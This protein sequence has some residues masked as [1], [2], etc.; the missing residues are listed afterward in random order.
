MLENYLGFK[1]KEEAV[2]EDTLI[3]WCA[4]SNLVRLKLALLVYTFKT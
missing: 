4:I 1:L 2:S 3:T